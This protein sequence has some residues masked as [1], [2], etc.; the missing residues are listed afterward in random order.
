MLHAIQDFFRARI[1]SDSAAEPDQHGLHL[2]TAA[3]LFEML[4][5]DTE[6]HPDER[7]VLEKALQA[8]FALD[9]METRELAALADREAAD[10]VSLYQFTGLIN[11]YFSPK[12]KL[13]VIEM[14]WQVALADGH[15]DRYEEA[16][17]RKVADLIHVPHRDFIQS[18]HRVMDASK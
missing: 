16:L 13:Q 3:L 11:E 4:R 7:P 5:A 14:L 12:Q 9:E 1:Q 18:K 2:A 6:E 15:L 10:A 17:V 8:C